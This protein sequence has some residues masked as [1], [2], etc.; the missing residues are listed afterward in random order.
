MNGPLRQPLV[1]PAP[2]V[3]VP[4]SVSK[5]DKTTPVVA[6]PAP[7]PVDTPAKPMSIYMTCD[8][9]FDLYVNGVKVGSGNSWTTT[10]HFT[11]V[12]KAGDV[13]AVDGIDRGGPAAFIGVFDD[14]VTTASDWRCSTKES[15]GWTKNS[16]DDASWSKAVSYSR[17]QDN[18][19]WRSVGGGSRPN[20][21]ANAEW[22][23]TSDNNN[24]D[25]VF[26]RYFPFGVVVSPVPAPSVVAAPVVAAPVVA[27]PV[28][29]APVVAARTTPKSVS[30]EIAAAH[31]TSVSGLSKLQERIIKIITETGIEQRK[32]EEENKKSYNDASATL[33]TTIDKLKLTKEIMVQ[34]QEDI[35][36]L[37]VTIHTHYRKL[38]HD[39]AYF[40][41]LEILKPTFLK[42][43]E[44]VGSKVKDIRMTVSN[45]IRN[46]RY[47][48]EMMTLLS[49][50]HFKTTNITGYVAQEF[51]DHYNQY[52]LR[53]SQD[54]VLYE[55]DKKKMDKLVAD[56]R[57]Q[58]QKFK[59]V[60]TE[61]DN[62]VKL[63]SRLKATYDASSA[64]NADLDELVQRVLS[65]LKKKN[66]M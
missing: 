8:N 38:I 48:L 10:Y 28:V 29:A 11:P 52:K 66:C 57:V 3:A 16:F 63:V 34:V 33:K 17:N 4:V 12:V 40:H 22:L 59:E 6:V 41:T 49:R 25:R 51:M 30:D 65:L 54:D 45:K 23:W 64:E 9:E 32:Y 2:I 42:S 18:N 36:K 20:I 27:A 1:T 21:P 61:Y 53:A 5:S 7:A 15:T 46:D 58:S 26:C 50:I 43:L 62:I 31:L 47:K 60:S 24:H 39:S 44:E 14:K 13:I 55:E 56:Y 19:I 35:N 37:N